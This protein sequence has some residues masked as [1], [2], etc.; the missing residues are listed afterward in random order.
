MSSCKFDDN[1]FEGQGNSN[2]KGS[3]GL[4][5]MKEPQLEASLN[6]FG[7]WK[8]S[9]SCSKATVKKW[10]AKLQSPIPK[11]LGIA[12]GIAI[13]VWATAYGYSQAIKVLRVV[14]SPAPI[15]A[16]RQAK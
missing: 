11:G 10:T 4:I 2:F 6:W 1:T 14:S 3:S 5:E 13:G 8:V 16:P 9:G 12:I 15:E 7:Q